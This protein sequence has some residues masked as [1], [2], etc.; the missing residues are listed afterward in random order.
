MKD[1]F[2]EDMF[3]GNNGAAYEMF[4]KPMGNVLHHW[5]ASTMINSVTY[6][7]GAARDEV[8][9]KNL[10]NVENA[11]TTIIR[12]YTDKNGDSFEWG[13]IV[14]VRVDDE[15]MIYQINLAGGSMG[16]YMAEAHFKREEI[17]TKVGIGYGLYGS[18]YDISD[19]GIKNPKEIK[20]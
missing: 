7:L 3:K 13:D 10:G 18:V 16:M 14:V 12:D 17:P 2:E 8:N 20:L 6:T 11:I 4:V 19:G 1:K 15:I 5:R 9:S